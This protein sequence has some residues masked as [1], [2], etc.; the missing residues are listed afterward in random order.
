MLHYAVSIT[1]TEA[2]LFAI[3]YS[4]NQAIQV[5]KVSHI[6]VITDTIYMMYQIFNLSVHSYQQQSIAISKDL[7]CFFNKYPLNSIKLWDCPSNNK[8]PL[9]LIV[10][11][12]TKNFNFIP[13]YLY[14]TSWDFDKKNKC[15]NI[16]Q[17]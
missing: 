12:E 7:R 14:K 6:I 8:W 2:E 15:N 17:N 16:I 13:L 11:K 1:S 10:N 4:I 3:R 5:S 9:H